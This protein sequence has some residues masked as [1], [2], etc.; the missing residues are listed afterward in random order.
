MEHGLPPTGG[1]GMGIDRLV[2]FLTDSN[3]IKEVLAFPANRPLPTAPQEPTPP[4][5]QGF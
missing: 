4:V 3:S 2:M 5:N 1:W